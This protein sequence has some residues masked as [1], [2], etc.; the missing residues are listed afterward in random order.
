MGTTNH[1]ESRSLAGK[2]H[3]KPDAKTLPT[4]GS[5]KQAKCIELLIN[6]NRCAWELIHRLK[7]TNAADVIYK[8]RGHGWQIATIAQ[9]D[10]PKHDVYQL[11]TPLETAKSALKAY[12]DQQ[13]AKQAKAVQA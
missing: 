1:N 13:Q 11:D 9:P 4:L 6:G 12:Y 7:V 8:L 10:D 2:T 5:D 3:C